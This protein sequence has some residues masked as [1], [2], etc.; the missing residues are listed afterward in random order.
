MMPSY[1]SGFRA[2]DWWKTNKHIKELI[3]EYQ[4]LVYYTIKYFM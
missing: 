3:I 2:D 4:K 1:Y